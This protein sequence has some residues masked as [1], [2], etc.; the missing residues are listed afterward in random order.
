[1]KNNLAKEI[2]QINVEKELKNSYL[3]YAMSVIVGRA[4]PDVRD[5]LKPVHRRILF[6][7][8]ILNNLWNKPYK[9]SARIVG[10][11]IGKYHPHG[12]SAVYDAI[13]RMAQ[14][15]S[16][17]YTLID[18]QGNFGSIDGDAAAAMRYTEVRMSKIA[19]ELLSDLEKKTVDF[20]PNYDG[21]EFIPKILPTKIPNLLINGSSGIAVGMATNIPPHN[22]AEVINGCVAYIDNEKMTVQDLIKYIPGPDFPT[23]GIIIGRSGIEK[24]Y[25]TG[26]GKISI[27]AKHK[28][29]T[30]IKSR[31]KSIIIHE[32]PYQVNKSRLI[33]KISEL[34]KEKK[35]EGISAL[36]DESD[37]DGM[38]I[39]IEIKK[40][41]ISEI[42]L[43][44]L[45]SL[46]QLQISFGINMVA[47]CNGRPKRL[48]LLEIIHSFILHRKQTVTRRSMFE[49]QK[50]EE[51]IH[52]LNGLSIAIKNINLI[53]KIIQS[54]KNS[55]EAK[56]KLLSKTWD[57]NKIENLILNKNDT[58]LIK[59]KKSNYFTEKQAQSIL[60]LRLSKLTNLE[61]EK[62]IDDKNN[63]LKKTKK[64]KKI[65]YNHKYMMEVI[66]NELLDIKKDFGDQRKTDIITSNHS[67]INLE[68][69]INPKDVVIT[70][71]Y[72]G[73]VKYQPISDYEAQK[74]GGRGKTAAKTKK[75]DFI[76]ILLVTNTLDTILCFSN[77]GILYWMKVYQ[78]P[79]SSRNARGRPII[80]LLPLQTKERITAIL[81]IKKYQDNIN[82]FMATS[83]GI[84]K[85]TALN[86]FNRPRNKGII[87]INLKN[88]D[89]LIGIALTNGKDNIMLFSASGK[90]VQFSE[91]SVRKMGR[92][93]SGVKGMK[94]NKND[95]V[96]SL[97]V[98][99]KLHSILIVTDKGYGKRTKITDFPIK[100][101]ATKGMIAM[102]QTKKN[103][104]VIAA[105]QVIDQDQIIIITNSGKLV[106]TRVSEL[107]ILGR[108]TQ[109]VILIRTSQKEKLV[110]IQRIKKIF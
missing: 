9:K 88:N 13:I 10:D 45:Y 63:L 92:T 44:Q 20:V 80:N 48:S 43:N 28:I 100:S 84:V 65:L 55:S 67:E 102:K 37:K 52:I 31:K 101:R 38:R 74:R 1:M 4:L 34:V 64:L 30:N 91:T 93:A 27:R 8:Y 33:E 81:P 99:K 16:L 103:G 96:V 105:I 32:I 14:Q 3:D 73:Y 79:E 59:E 56:A 109:G 86:E 62:I 36:R 85:K 54:S 69:M 18:G 2:I 78:L 82:I 42:I 39:V 58:N 35:I 71:S 68:D 51:K 15:F 22:I 97:I 19:H 108:N 72:S 87:A 26:K 57:N 83:H 5:G 6:A 25:K 66:R 94:M 46:S 41:A 11:V 95:R 24:A 110:A 17:R 50:C 76:K 70:L 107:R 23:S 21:S 89:E 29:E 49:L 60:E 47:L 75:T 90:T 61:Y 104:I 53:I 7:M 40:E 98:P 106:R 12:D 77:K